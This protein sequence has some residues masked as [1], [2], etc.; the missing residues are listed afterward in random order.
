MFGFRGI[1][2]KNNKNMF[3]GMVECYETIVSIS[4]D[5]YL[6][7]PLKMNYVIKYLYFYY[8]GSAI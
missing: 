8:I 5:T 1:K 7:K 3:V 4:I 6:L 2:K